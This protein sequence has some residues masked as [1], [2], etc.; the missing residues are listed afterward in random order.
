ME[1]YAKQIQAIVFMGI[2]IF[3]S[4]AYLNFINYKPPKG[5]DKPQVNGT[6]HSATFGIP[7]PN[8]AIQLSTNNTSEGSQITL[9]S[10][11]SP[12]DV[13][14][15]Y[16]NVYISKGWEIES[17]GKAGVFLGT[18]FKKKNS[19]ERVTVTSSRQ[20]E[21]DATTVIIDIL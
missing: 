15:F 13:Q 1:S 19:P 7:F 20:E 11:L 10:D 3:G 9:S 8:G 4:V 12:E 17:E 16:K 2:F 5:S 6:S 18:E 21:F 14:Q